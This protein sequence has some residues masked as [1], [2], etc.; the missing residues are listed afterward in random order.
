MD[1]TYADFVERTLELLPAV[2]PSAGLSAALLAAYDAQRAPRGLWARL[3]QIVWPDAPLWAPASA[4]AA[5]LLLGV[6][7]GVLLPGAG[8]EGTRFSL[9]Q[10]SSFSLLTSDMEEDL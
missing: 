8:D 9:D 1:E 7:L 6:S 5:A 2:A 3:C 4:F 10:P